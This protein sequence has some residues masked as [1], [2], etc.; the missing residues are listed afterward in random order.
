MVS[1]VDGDFSQSL[2]DLSLVSE[3]DQKRLSQKVKSPSIHA[4]EDRR[5]VKGITI[6]N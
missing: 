2:I 5:Y 1:G 3:S 4:I 6:T